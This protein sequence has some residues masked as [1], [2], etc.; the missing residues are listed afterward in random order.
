MQVIVLG[1][2]VI[3]TLVAG[4]QWASK[5]GAF[6]ARSAAW[7]TDNWRARTATTAATVTLWGLW[8]YL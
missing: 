3:A 8:L 7:A 6:G 1:A 5:L 2:S 4:C